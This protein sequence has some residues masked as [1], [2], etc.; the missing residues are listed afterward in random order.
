MIVNQSNG[1]IEMSI[2]LAHR[3]SIFSYLKVSIKFTNT[4]AIHPTAEAVGFLAG[5]L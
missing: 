5:A 2:F 3:H 1:G 4:A